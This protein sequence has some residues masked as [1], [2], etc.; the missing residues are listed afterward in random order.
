[1]SWKPISTAPRDGSEFQAWWKDSWQPRAR[2]DPEYGSFQLWGR[3]DYDTEGWEVFEI[4]GFWMPQPLSPFA[5]A[6]P[7]PESEGGAHD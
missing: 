6:P 3:T 2:F 5:A 4:D 1:M 7:A